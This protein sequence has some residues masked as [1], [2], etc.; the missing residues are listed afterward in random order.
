MAQL[1]SIILEAPHAKLI[2]E[3]IQNKIA[4]PVRLKHINEPAYIVA[5]RVCYGIIRLTNVEQI[6]ESQFKERTP[7]HLVTDEERSQWDEDSTIYI[8]SF[9]IA[10]MFNK[11]KACE[12]IQSRHHAKYVDFK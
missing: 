4:K 11:P 3:G 7:E 1:P 6:T 12:Y 8:H 10:K 9:S 2:W 5:D